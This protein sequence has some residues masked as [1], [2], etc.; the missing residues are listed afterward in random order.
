[1]QEG[2]V[3]SRPHTRTPM[4]R[5]S[6]LAAFLLA[7]SSLLAQTP[8]GGALE[9]VIVER[10]Y[11]ADGNDAA[12]EDGSAQLVEGAVTYRVFLDMKE[13]Y[14]LQVLG[15]FVGHPITF[16]TTTTFFNNED[17][18]EAWGDAI[19]DIYLDQNT[20][21]IDSWLSA[22]AASDAHWGILKSDDT[23]PSIV[24][25]ANNDGGSNGVPEGLLSNT[26]GFPI[27]LTDS[28]GLL[29]D[30][31]APP[32]ST[33]VGT[34]PEI[35][36]TGGNSYSDE[37][38]GLAVLGDLH[39]PTPGNKLL[40]GQFTTDGIFSFC[41]N[42]WLKIP[43]SL[44]CVDCPDYLIYYANLL[45]GD[46]SESAGVLGDY[47]FSIPGLCYS[48]DAQTVDCLGIPGGPALPGTACDDGNADT[49]NDVYANDCACVGED[50]L[51]VLGGN[52]L[53]GQPCDDGNPDTSGEVWVEGC[54]C[55]STGIEENSHTVVSVYPN[56]TRDMLILEIT[57]AV[58]DRVTVDLLDALG[59]R[60][61]RRDLGAVSGER[62]ERFD[63]SGLSAGVYFLETTIA[64]R[65]QRTRI[66]KF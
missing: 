54:N 60:V 33:F 58:G 22:G 30:T 59:S 56:P 21:A 3:A 5:H 64:G 39:C 51:G 57:E 1:M 38:F 61:I 19:N 6:T 16:N 41:L 11:V 26:T 12:D 52:A 7:S 32:Q 40:I 45:P 50:C 20:V 28:D 66:T 14:D 47:T 43:D 9:G 36:N 63:L 65:P 23:D 18:G 34:A 8:D 13:G 46:T 4:N 35:F 62:R 27:P 10:Y 29:L 42:L 49:Q 15:G 31:A 2:E 17:R 48:S 37:N 53:P 55:L 25:G 44:V 24:G